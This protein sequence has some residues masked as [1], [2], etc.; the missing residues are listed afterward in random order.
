[1][2]DEEKT[3]TQLINELA[4]T[5]QRIAELETAEI[6]RV[7]AEEALQES[8][9]K[10]R[11]LVEEINDVIYAVDGD[12]VVTYISP[13][14]EPLGGYAI[15]EII[16]RPLTDFIFPEDVPR[17]EELFQE[18]ISTHL[19][20]TTEYRIL[21][22]SGEI[23]WVRAFSRPIFVENR[24]VGLRGVITDITARKVAEESLRQR[25]RELALL[26][27]ASRAVTS[28]LDLDR[29][30]VTVFGEVRHLLGVVASSIWLLDPATGELVCRQSTGS[31]NEVVCGWRLSPGEGFAGWVARN[32]KCLI[33][34]DTRLDERHFKGV[35]QQTGV[36]LRSILSV[37][38]WAKHG[39]IG[40]LQVV[41]T[42]VDRFSTADLELL[43]PLAATV[44]MS[45]ENARLYE[46][47][48]QEIAERRRVEKALRELNASLETQV[49][50]R[51]AEIRAEQEKSEAIL[52][53]VGD[54]IAVI[55]FE[56][57]VQYINQAFTALTGYTASEARGFQVNSLIGER[58][59]VPDQQSLQLALAR[60]E[61]WQGEVT[62]QR[63][64]GRTYDAALTITPMRDTEGEVAGYVSSHHDISQ[65]KELD[66][67]RSRFITSISHELRTPVANMKLYANLLRTGRQ[68]E[69]TEH[70]LQVL[71]K[72]ADRLAALIEDMLEI[73]GLD[74]GQAVMA[75]EPVLLP[76][77]IGDTITRYQSRAE[78]SGLTLAAMPIPPDLP[79]VKGDQ[80][81]LTQALGELVENAV[82]FTP[83]GG[84]V[85]VEA[86]TAKEE[87]HW[88]VTV[89]VRDTGPGI[90]LEEQEHVFDR[91][92][93]GSLA[94]SG[95][96][97]GTG[98][99]LSIAEEIM[100]AH[101]GRIEVE[102]HLGEGCTFTVWLSVGAVDRRGN[103]KG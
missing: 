45:I 37:P 98:L 28:T 13:V 96:V 84:Q 25:N 24:V 43:V 66:R 101:G 1:M 40:V 72:Q 54:A 63:K 15:S 27:R 39:A 21:T 62:I 79:V 85:T 82:V 59:S 31:Q 102:S 55:D 4:E 97:P 30:L 48:Q 5:R 94:E 87:G 83:A 42:E 67:A 88:W 7:R 70:Y 11:H 49:A 61:A 58:L 23:H 65:R 90:S 86:R 100:R 51:T 35:D 75:W 32:G 26:N 44:A 18:I 60:G 16:G 47:A 64:D 8:E 22:R 103:V 76:T 73:T 36:E 99:G 14:V 81:R 93:R 52:C 46:Q 50:A 38:L 56:M 77:V 95:H 6:K 57:R 89:A 74:S 92:Y 9:E 33:V 71:V 80:A 91:F 17:A 68:P 19:E 20:R 34:A 41:D 12:G 2:K 29:V 10:Y 53:S 69:K 78:A 3:K